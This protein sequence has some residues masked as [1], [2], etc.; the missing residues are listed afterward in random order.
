MKVKPFLTF[1]AI[2][3]IIFGLGFL[4][5]PV[6]S[7]GLFGISLNA[8]GILL[9]RYV[10]TGFVAIFL[11]CWLNKDASPEA[12]KTTTYILA[13]TDTIGFVVSLVGQLA[14]VPSALGWMTVAL[15]FVLAA[16]NIY[17]QWFA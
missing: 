5:L 13:V 2:I 15:W 3:T 10:G 14:G 4:L 7:W 6:S 17:F 1:K 16:G 9:S 11:L 8:Q 12:Q